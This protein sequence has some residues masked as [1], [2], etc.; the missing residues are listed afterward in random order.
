MSKVQDQL[1][2]RCLLEAMLLMR[3]HV[4]IKTVQQENKVGSVY[5]GHE[6]AISDEQV[7]LYVTTLYRELTQ[8]LT[9]EQ[10][11]A[12]CNSEVVN[13]LAIGSSILLGQAEEDG[14]FE[15]VAGQ[16]R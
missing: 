4:A 7:G 12:A 16:P 14:Q 13:D 2:A 9:P 6:K 10:K 11:V 15:G 1:E 5:L 3:L 8:A